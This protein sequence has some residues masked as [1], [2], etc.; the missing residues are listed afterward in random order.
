MQTIIGAFDDKARAHAAR[1]KLVSAG[2]DRSD[3]HVEEGDAGDLARETSSSSRGAE[4]EKPG[5]IRS[6]FSSLF[7]DEDRS[8][9]SSDYNEAVRRGSAV[10]VVDAENETQAEQAA[11]ILDELGAYDV[12]DR[13]RQWQA[14]G[15]TGSGMTKE[16]LSSTG[17]AATDKPGVLNVVQE[18]LRV[19]KRT[20]DRGGVRVIQ[21]VSQKPVREIVR[22]REEHAVVERR[23]VDRP[24]TAQDLANFKEG[25][26]EVRETTEEAVVA[27]EARV[28]EEVR[29]GKEVREREETIED[30]LRRTDVDVERVQGRSEERERAYA[31]DRK[32]RPEPSERE[33]DASA[34]PGS[35]S[36]GKKTVRKNSPKS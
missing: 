28:V 8:D 15:G 16:T 1:E 23:P 36:E 10:V 29:V 19:G 2:F 17:A 34:A 22:L 3:V 27:K 4:V 11:E 13:A 25:S 18:E 14:G 24:A 9:W 21:R 31:A 12:K 20:L 7:G 30:Q 26:I 32:D 33:R 5:A 35:P 6:F